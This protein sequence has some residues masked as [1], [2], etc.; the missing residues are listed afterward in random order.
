ML[1]RLNDIVK[2]CYYFYSVAIFYSPKVSY[3][4]DIAGF[5]ETNALR[6]VGLPQCTW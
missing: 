4:L 3:L 2:N 1:Q 5:M 6:W